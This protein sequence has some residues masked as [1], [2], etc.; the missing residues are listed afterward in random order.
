MLIAI[1]LSSG[2]R[3]KACET[4]YGPRSVLKIPGVPRLWDPPIRGALKA[5]GS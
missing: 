2:T 1:P 3:V 5:A 4:N